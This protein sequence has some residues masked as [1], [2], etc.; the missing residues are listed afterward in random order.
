MKP[1]LSTVHGLPKTYCLWMN[2]PTY[3]FPI[4]PL[5]KTIQEH[6]HRILRFTTDTNSILVEFPV[7]SPTNNIPACAP[8]LMCG[9]Y[10]DQY[11]Y[12][13]NLCIYLRFLF[14]H[15]FVKSLD[16]HII[17]LFVRYLKRYFIAIQRPQWPITYVYY[18]RLHENVSNHYYIKLL[19]A[20]SNTI[21]LRTIWT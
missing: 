16:N 21:C 12:Q 8:C 14:P 6:R 7:N 17:G 3:L 4:A 10:P 1:C 20:R 13:C 2:L 18:Y 9:N 15:K 19:I 11:D 5:G